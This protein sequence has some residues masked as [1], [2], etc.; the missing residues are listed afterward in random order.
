MPLYEFWCNKCGAAFE[1]RQSVADHEQHK[2][3]CPRCHS[4]A[5]IEALLSSFS[6]VTSR[7]S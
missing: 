4:A 3:E 6:P 5:R 1:A 7:K 2:P